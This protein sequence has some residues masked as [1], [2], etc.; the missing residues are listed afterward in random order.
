M[1]GSVSAR[2]IDRLLRGSG[3]TDRDLLPTRVRHDRGT[4]SANGH[5][6]SFEPNCHA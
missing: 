5:V 6:R 2:Y 1:T 3:V 4:R